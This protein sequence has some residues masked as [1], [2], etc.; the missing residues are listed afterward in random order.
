MSAALLQGARGATEDVDLWFESIGDA[1][2]ADAAR[3][4]GGFWITRSC[5]IAGRAEVRM[6]FC[7]VVGPMKRTPKRKLELQK[8]TIA[9]LG[10]YQLQVVQGGFPPARPKFTQDVYCPSQHSDC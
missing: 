5:G 2:I 10:N 6:W 3:R 7:L 8:N 1:R 4:A 9:N